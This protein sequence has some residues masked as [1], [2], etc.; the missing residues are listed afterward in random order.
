MLCGFLYSSC[1]IT[2]T[3]IYSG[4]CLTINIDT[5]QKVEKE[6]FSSIFKNVGCIVLE[7]TDYSLLSRVDKIA[8]LS[9]Y[10]YVLE[11][12]R[13]LFQFDK[14]GKFI[15][16]IGDKG[17]GPGEYMTPADLTVDAVN[18][19]L[20][21]LD[22]Q[23]QSVLKYDINGEY[24]SSVKLENSKTVSHYIQYFDGNL[25]TNLYSFDS[26]GD[27][28]LL[29]K[30]DI[31]TGSRTSSFLR[32]SQYSKGWNELFF[33]EQG[34][35]ISSPMGNPKFLNLFMDTI[36]EIGK[37]GLTPYLA[38]QSKNL[39]TEEYMASQR[40]QGYDASKI[41]DGL[42]SAGM[43][44]NITSF[45]ESNEYIHFKY[46]FNNKL[47]TVLHKK[48]VDST[49]VIQYMINDLLYSDESGKMLA[50][51]FISYDKDKAYTVEMNSDFSKEYFLDNLKNNKI[52]SKMEGAE[53]LKTLTEESN[54]I[55]VY[56]KFK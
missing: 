3:E 28:Y 48:S 29:S 47:C 8:F 16:M 32:A 1:N 22:S 4:E 34:C 24:E 2:N 25:Y 7:T 43:I 20:Y 40:E 55:I 30:I 18:E 23:S 5:V 42:R 56:Y 33:I 6:F 35:F 9:N 45:F 50:S 17:I 15:R 54:P 41:Y 38:L 36:F 39:V 21:L 44:Y 13:G 14:S 11:V 31:N 51:K 52:N 49:S 26:S 46:K 37:E 53:G 12:G 19:K 27:N 10:L